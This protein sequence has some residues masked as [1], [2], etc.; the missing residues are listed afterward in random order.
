MDFTLGL[1][2]G[3]HN[4][5]KLYGDEVRP[6]GKVTGFQSGLKAAGKGLSLGLYDGITG[7]VT[8]PLKGAKEEGAAGFFKG[9]GRGI[10]GVVL[11]GGAGTWNTLH[12]QNY[13]IKLL[14]FRL[15][16]MWGV[17][18]YTMKGIHREIQKLQ[19]SD[20][21]KYIINSRI[22]MS[23]AEFQQS[24]A[25]E[26]QAILARWYDLR[27]DKTRKQKKKDIF[28]GSVFGLRRGVK[29]K[30]N[31][32]SKMGEV[33]TP[34]TEIASSGAIAPA[35]LQ[36]APGV[37]QQVAS[38]DNKE[39]EKAI[40]ESVKATSNGNATEDSAIEAAIRASISELQYV[41]R[42]HPI[43]NV[44]DEEEAY[45]RAIR[46]SMAEASRAGGGGG[47]VTDD[48][49]FEEIRYKSLTEQGTPSGYGEDDLKWALTESTRYG[50]SPA[51]DDE[52][53]FE[54]ALRESRIQQKKPEVGLR[55]HE[56]H[57]EELL[58]A[59]AESKRLDE[60]RETRRRTEEEVV[61]EYVMKASLEEQ[62][63]QKRRDG[64]SS[65]ASRP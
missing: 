29:D 37:L 48:R 47:W 57:D 34:E 5:P 39:L 31:D 54:R 2:Q 49:E 21:D 44:D 41:A 55:F 23:E 28:D 45:Q 52:V 24:T 51:R 9:F 64:R 46:D 58:K 43:E 27:F 20:V 16:A 63:Y 56:E 36:Y 19:G 32:K 42:N 6:T 3:F 59:I 50:G 25:R 18:G 40:Q 61:M 7:L 33:R 65:W 22:V 26:Q 15:T 53:E 11:K 60:E 17:P 13:G 35:P 62:E 38:Y 12:P 14:T 10:G 1:A 30:G 4:A 8:Q